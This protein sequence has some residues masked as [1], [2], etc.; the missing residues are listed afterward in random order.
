MNP[1]RARKVKEVNARVSCR[2]RCSLL[3]RGEVR[4]I[5]RKWPKLTPNRRPASVI[6]DAGGQGRERG[7]RIGV[8]APC[9]RN[10]GRED[11]FGGHGAI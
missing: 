11:D 9:K 10:E 4:L 7:A 8:Y 1:Y 6:K 3:R 2:A 5:L